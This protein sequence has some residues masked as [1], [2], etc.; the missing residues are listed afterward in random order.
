[1]HDPKS[2]KGA[3][4]SK[5]RNTTQSTQKLLSKGTKS[6][7]QQL[8]ILRSLFDDMDLNSD[9]FIDKHDIERYMLQLK[10]DERPPFFDKWIEEHDFDNDGKVSFEDY[11]QY[12]FPLFESGNHSTVDFTNLK[13]DMK[14]II[15]FGRLK[16][17]LERRKLVQLLQSLLF[18]LHSKSTIKNVKELNSFNCSELLPDYINEHVEAFLIQLGLSYDKSTSSYSFQESLSAEQLGSIHRAISYF[19]SSLADSRL[20][21]LNS[22]NI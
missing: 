6:S 1:M 4:I 17:K 15:A 21:D 16:L 10:R 9:G 14:L 19:L 3:T 8:V 20:I 5:T 13:F 2:R 11:L 7:D 22:G 18:F 12:H